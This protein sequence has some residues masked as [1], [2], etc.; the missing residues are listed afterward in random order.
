MDKIKELRAKRL[1]V[2]E[3]MKGVLAEGDLDGERR[4]KYEAA[5]ADF[6]KLTAELEARERAEAIEARMNAPVKI[7]GQRTQE[8]PAVNDAELRNKA[9]RTYLTRGLDRMPAEQRDALEFRDL[10]DSS[11][12]GSAGGYTVP[13]GFLQKITERLKYF[14][15]MRQVSNVIET[16]SGQDLPWPTND[17]TSN[18]G[19]ILG[20]NQQISELDVTFGQ[21]MLKAYVWTSGLVRVPNTLLNDSAFDLETWLA[22]KFGQRL[23]RGQNQL[24]TVGSGHGSNQPLGLAT[25]ASSIN[26]DVTT[27]GNTA[28]T[29]A[30]LLSVLHGIDPAYRDTASWQFSD[31]GLKAVRSIVDAN[32]RPIFVPAGSFGSLADA[33]TPDTLLG[34]PIR[35]NSHLNAWTSGSH[36]TAWGLFGDY[37]AAYVIRDVV[38]IQTMRLTERYADYLQTGFFA[39]MRTDGIVDDVAAYVRISS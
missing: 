18:V 10:S 4:T 14:G 15:P 36:V 26:A 24:F 31:A 38:G 17:D 3:S 27:A 35:I 12:N 16:A 29:Y 33:A 6:D 21:N 19:S 13:Q 37:S 11:A 7:D 2:W 30:D 22:K 8:D 25:N 20:E 9:F 32:S 23:G 39:Y 5:E 1:Q 28:V 34:K